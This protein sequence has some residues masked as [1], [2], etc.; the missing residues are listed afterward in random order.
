LRGKDEQAE[1]T[2]PLEH[3]VEVEMI[4]GNVAEGILVGLNLLFLA[5]AFLLGGAALVLLILRLVS[6]VREDR[7]R[8]RRWASVV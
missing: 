5:P 4:A 7:R 2:Q 1:N 8:R 6:L 3:T